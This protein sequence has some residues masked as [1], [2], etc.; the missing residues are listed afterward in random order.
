MMDGVVDPNYSILPVEDLS[1]DGSLI[2]PQPEP[3]QGLS[4]VLHTLEI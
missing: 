1:F 2:N 3:S 4:F